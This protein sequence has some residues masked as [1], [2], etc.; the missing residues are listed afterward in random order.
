M[1]GTSDP[2]LLLA[3]EK[4]ARGIEPSSPSPPASPPRQTLS[5]PRPTSSSSSSYASAVKT[6]ASNNSNSTTNHANKSS[7]DAVAAAAAALNSGKCASDAIALDSDDEIEEDDGNSFTSPAPAA[8]NTVHKSITPFVNSGT[9]KPVAEANL[10]SA[11]KEASGHIADAFKRAQSGHRPPRM[12]PGLAASSTTSN[13]AAASSTSSA[14]AAGFSSPF[15][16]TSDNNWGFQSSNHY[17]SLDEILAEAFDT[18]AKD[19][20]LPPHSPAL[21]YYKFIPYHT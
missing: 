7:K 12:T 20:K 5:K 9:T 10:K 15:S 19:G 14:S 16:P 11:Q 21:T 6:G 4:V 13:A 3:C 1:Y 8:S 2:S 17:K 18:Q